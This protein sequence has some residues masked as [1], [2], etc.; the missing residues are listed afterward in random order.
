MSHEDGSVEERP[1]GAPSTVE[2]SPLTP[3]ESSPREPLVPVAVSMAVGVTADTILS[4]P[5]IAWLV[6]ACL[7]AGTWWVW[8]RREPQCVGVMALLVALAAAA[9]A[10]THGYRHSMGRHDIGRFG[11]HGTRGVVCDVAR[12][13]HLRRIP[14]EGRSPR[15]TQAHAVQFLAR[16]ER[17]RVADRWRRAEGNVLVVVRSHVALP[18]RWPPR[19]TLRLCGELQPW[20]APRNPAPSSARDYWQLKRVRCRI[21]VESSQAVRV[22]EPTRRGW[23]VDGAPAWI[24]ALRG[25]IRRVLMH[26]LSSGRRGLAL[27]I[28][29]GDR[30]ELTDEE[31]RFFRES[32]TA[33]LLAVSGMH[34]ALAL[35]WLLWADRLGWL[36]RRWSPWC[37][38]VAALG[39]AMLVG[40]QPPVWRATTMLIVYSWGCARLRPIGPRQQLAAVAIAMWLYRPTCWLEIGVQLSLM[41][42][43]VLCWSHEA[44]AK[45]S[46]HEPLERLIIS[47]RPALLRAL[48]G[49]LHWAFRLLAMSLAVVTWTNPLV[50]RAFGESSWAG[51]LLSPALAVCMGVSLWGGWSM[52]LADLV[53]WQSAAAALSPIVAGS[54]SLM[55]ATAQWASEWF[56][57][58][59]GRG[60]PLM[61]LLCS[62]GSFVLGWS[63]LGR[64]W[65]YRWGMAL[66]CVAVSVCYLPSVAS[67]DHSAVRCTF[68]SVGHGTCVLLQTPDGTTW[69]YDAGTMGDPAAKSR[70]IIRAVRLLGAARIDHAVVTHCDADHFNLL[71]YLAR[72]LGIGCLW[73]TRAA[74]RRRDA[75]FEQVLEQLGARGIAWRELSVGTLVESNSYRLRVLHPRGGVPVSGVVR[76]DNESSAVVLLT[77]GETGL[78][79]PGDLEGQGLEDAWPSIC[80]A[81]GGVQL[82][83]MAPHHGSRH[84]V[85]R[86]WLRE[87]RPIGIVV[88]GSV[89]GADKA[90][91]HWYMPGGPSVIHTSRGAVQCLSDGRGWQVTQWNGR[92]W[93]A[94]PRGMPGRARVV[95]KGG[96]TGANR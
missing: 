86:K 40:G 13:G 57:P 47:A 25:R 72:D 7:A 39:Y 55:S 92:S 26:R 2:R 63:V 4:L 69:L 31:Q 8:G 14:S 67:E 96:A 20:E 6:T 30:S 48:H 60:A 49:V 27:A 10:R 89:R 18:S 33:H 71:P 51:V 1:A 93:M 43:G 61:V 45:N 37:I 75:Q 11:S 80:A 59:A 94:E 21:V 81:T 41:A 54:L 9:A 19:G 22:M 79:L 5:A 65:K 3:A 35:G 15:W 95:N 46:R 68:F 70:E 77:M 38:T 58:T 74:L 78:L 12:V 42:V 23:I 76:S 83:L 52:V 44:L 29:L 62:Y 50:V 88:S 84:S 32:G 85:P 90:W 24:E 53:G 28:L 64:R 82:L 56:P 73:T 66:G 87:L 91:Q 17:L 36:P 34:V 16:I